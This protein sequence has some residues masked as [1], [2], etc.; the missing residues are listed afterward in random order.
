MS[1]K[2]LA[3]GLALLCAAPASQAAFWHSSSG[4]TQTHYPIVLVHGLFGFD[5]LAGVDYWYG[6]P[7]ALSKDGAKVYVV[8]VSAANSTEVR[9]EQ[10]LAQI[11]NIL[12]LT[13]ADKVN[14]IGHSHGG[15][16]ARYAASI[17][18]DKVASVT[19]VGGV[20]WGSSFADAVRGAIPQ[21]S[22]SEDIIAGAFNA[23]AGIIEF[24]SGTPADPQ[25][26]V[27]ALESLTTA[28]T[29][30]F[31]ARYPEGMPSQYCGQGDEQAGN[32][33]YYY[34]WSGASTVTNVL[35][36][37]DAGLL[38]TSLVFSEPGDGLVSSC[39]SH[40]GKV[41]RDNYGMNHLDEVN[42]TFG[43]V[44]L[45]ETNPKTLFRTQANRLK[46]LG[47]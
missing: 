1:L 42:Q 26:A 45:F 36:V 34:S 32:G 13:G 40:L 17:S 38:A 35:D 20:N 33:V 31:N 46:N 28:G 44:N 30:A 47:L 27:A 14:L 8:N 10:L 12:A 2:P 16:T 15:P 11:D 24:L 5:S 7:S 3:L 37:S 39:S 9:G 21:D 43:L 25:D 41:I 23:F 18:P 6:I 22:L 29:L 4:Y 19:S